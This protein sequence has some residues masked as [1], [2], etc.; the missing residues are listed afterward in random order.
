[1]KKLLDFKYP[2]ITAYPIIAQPLSILESKGDFAMPWLVSQY[3]QTYAT[4]N[5]EILDNHY[6]TYNFTSGVEGRIDLLNTYFLPRDIL[7]L[8]WVDI[9]DFIIN[10]IDMGYYVNTSFD[11]YYVPQSH[12]Y[13]NYHLPHAS[14]IYGYDTEC[15]TFNCAD[16][17]RGG[18]YSFEEVSF[19]DISNAYKNVDYSDITRGQAMDYLYFVR[20]WKMR[21]GYEPKLNLNLLKLTLSDYLNSRDSIGVDQE[22]WKLSFENVKFVYGLSCYNN[23]IKNNQAGYHDIRDIHIVYDRANFF[24]SKLEY[25]LKINL[26]NELDCMFLKRKQKRLADKALMLRSKYLKC[27]IKNTD[28]TECMNILLQVKSLDEDFCESFYRIVDKNY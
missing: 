14:V 3:I 11:L 7:D 27:V 10:M 8:K 1:M 19:K 26:L 12:G 5:K 28:V 2:T 21:E 25:L 16:F 18:K 23:I 13:K 17:F 24:E 4:D 22:T 20:L 9:T 6:V 15:E